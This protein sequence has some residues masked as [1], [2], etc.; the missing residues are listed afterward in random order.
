VQGTGILK[1]NALPLA[2]AYFT[3]LY[4][5]SLVRTNGNKRGFLKTKNK[6]T[7]E[8]LNELKTRWEQYTGENSDG[9][10]VLNAGLEFQETA[11]TPEQ[12]QMS[13]RK[14]SLAADI[15]GIFGVSLSVINGNPSD[16]EYSAAIKIAVLPV[17][18]SIEAALNQDLLLESEKDKF[19]F[20]F[21]TK[22]LLRGSI[23]KRY[24]AYKDGI[25]SNVLQID[26]ARYME[27]LPSLDLTFIKLGLQDVLYDPKTKTFFVPN[28]GAAGSIESAPVMTGEEQTQYQIRSVDYIQDE[29]TGQMQGSR[30]KGGVTSDD[31]KQ[32]K[33]NSVQIE[34]EKDNILPGLNQEDLAELGKDD[35]PVLLKKEVIDRNLRRHPDVA[36][37][38]YNRIIGQ[39][40][41]NSDERFGGKEYHDPNYMNFI[42]YNGN[43]AALTLIE[44]A[45]RKDNYE[46]V[47]LFE[48]SRTNIEK[49]KP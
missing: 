14:K 28:T 11:A 20:T 12:L 10:M 30:P 48:P 35:K 40:L 42:K 44:L 24:A 3:M 49:M 21:D 38:E 31:E 47:H 15:C 26:E 46:I 45:D 41:Y 27:N 1:E 39:A 34:T 25:A 17:L 19:K 9:L 6:I 2:V 7:Q 33:I 43:K 23:E 4:E 16:D 36:I 29:T 22:E 37:E 8:A 32:A 5:K 13:E 18:A